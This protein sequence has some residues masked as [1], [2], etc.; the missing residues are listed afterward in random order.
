MPDDWERVDTGTP[1][2]RMLSTA[3]TIAEDSEPLVTTVT[4]DDPL[5]PE[6]LHLHTDAGIRA[7]T[8]RFDITWTTKHYYKYH[9][10]EGPTFNYRYDRHPRIDLPDEHFHEPPA[11]GHDD[12]VPSCIDVETVRLVTLAVLQ[13]WR[14]TVESGDVDQLQQP[15]PP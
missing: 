10:T 13:L 11:A 9:Y 2:P 15:D 1:D 8:G 14:D 6:T 7:D 5:D 3:R 12:A 4:F